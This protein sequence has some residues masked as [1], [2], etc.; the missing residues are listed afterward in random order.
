M[1]E[2]VFSS[3]PAPRLWRTGKRKRKLFLWCST[4]SEQGGGAGLYFCL[5]GQFF[6]GRFSTYALRF[7]TQKPNTKPRA[8]PRILLNINQIINRFIFNWGSLFCTSI[9]KSGTLYTLSGLDAKAKSKNISCST[10]S[11]NV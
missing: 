8:T 7:P 11:L 10:A 1:R 3:P 4:L 2:P 6:D 9:R 5:D